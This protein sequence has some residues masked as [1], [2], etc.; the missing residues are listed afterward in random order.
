MRYSVS[1]DA[2]YCGPCVIFGR[3]EAKE[4]LFI[5]KVTDWSNLSC[6]VKRHLREGSPH[7][8][9][10]AMADNFVHINSKDSA[11]EAIIYKLSEFKKTQVLKNRH[12]LSKIIETLLLCGKQNIAIRGH[13]P[14]LSNFMAILNSKA[15][16]DDILT[17]H[18]TNSSSRAKYT[19]PDIQNE[20]INII[21][22]Q[23]RTSIVESC[24]N[25]KFFTLIAD[26]TTDTSTREQVSVC[27]R[28][29]ERDPISNKISIKEDFLD[30]VMATSTTGEHLAELLIE[31]L[32]NAGINT[33]NMRAQGYDGAANMSGKYNGVQARILQIVP[34]AMYVHCKSHCLNLAIVHSCKDTSVRNVMST[35]QEVAFSFDYSSKKLQA[36]YQELDSDATTKENMDKRT[37]LR[38]LCETRWT[39]RA[40]ALYTFKT[41]FPVVVHALERLQGLGDD[42]AGQ[43]L[44][45][46]TRFEF[47]IALVVSEHILQSTVY[48]SKFLQ[49]IECDLLEAT[50]ECKTVIELLR[51]ER[52]DESVWDELYQSALDLSEPFDIVENMPRRCG[53]QTTRANHP[54]DTPKQYWKV[55]LY[56]A[57][58]EHMIM[59]LESR[60]IKSENRFFAQY[61]L[62]RVIG[63]ITNEQI[64]TLY[65][66]YQTDLTCNLDEFKREVVR[67]RTRWSIT[68]RDQM[69]TSLC[70]TLD[71]VNPV[72]YPSI[73]TILCIMLTMPVTSA[74]AERSFSVLRRL[75]TYVR[76]TMKNDRLSSLAL[77]HIH[78]DFSVD[79]DK[80]M[81]KFVSAKTRRTD[82]GQ[83]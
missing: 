72:L 52:L 35:V 36:F 42:K 15:Q 26:E 77:M 5:N 3:N 80:I 38:T 61:L 79:L 4:K 69:P 44:A 59:E 11:D 55:S 68:P 39:S 83:F 46:I 56:I 75:K 20:I 50:K 78:R 34:G 57:F 48:L 70:E 21:G 31:T 18:L 54:A 12:V 63:N 23:I 51:A 53:R 49:G 29:L 41:S 74:T 13:I 65:E 8:N 22:N 82:F 64:A 25:S 67:W 7:F 2:L 10:Q 47:V 1:E 30:F 9:Y 32:N 62:P 17:D 43:Y 28:Y 37:K 66:T 45:S 24:N 60:L 76:S 6:F 73:D 40:D 81:E 19:S 16:G 27:L 33:M 14:Q 58:I 71:A